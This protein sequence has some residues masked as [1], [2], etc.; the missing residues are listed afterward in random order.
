MGTPELVNAREHDLLRGCQCD[1]RVLW[2]AARPKL[3]PDL[4]PG[5]FAAWP[6]GVVIVTAFNHGKRGPPIHGGR[7]SRRQT[8]TRQ[9]KNRQ[10]NFHAGQ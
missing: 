6:D 3:W 8:E 4:I 1:L 2:I 9:N 7:S 5:N 10:A